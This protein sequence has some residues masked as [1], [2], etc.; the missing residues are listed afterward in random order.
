M[1]GFGTPPEAVVVV[2]KAVLILKQGEKKN[3]AW[4][5]GQKMMGNPKKFIDDI[6]EFDGDNI[7]QWKLDALAPILKEDFFNQKT[8]QSKSTAAALLCG[9]VINI[10]TYNSI[11][12]KVK[13]LKEAAEAA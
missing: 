5:N 3:H 1:K 12:K 8:M 13:P 2:A 10:V 11:F 6:K 9:W 7:D 4:Q